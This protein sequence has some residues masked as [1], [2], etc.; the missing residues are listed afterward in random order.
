MTTGGDPPCTHK[1]EMDHC[2]RAKYCLD[3]KRS[4]PLEEDYIQTSSRRTTLHDR[5]LK[6][7]TVPSIQ[8]IISRRDMVVG[9]TSFRICYRRFHIVS[10]NIKIQI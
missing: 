1:H 9:F 3:S 8:T 2:R 6:L 5:L 4:T 10:D 7:I